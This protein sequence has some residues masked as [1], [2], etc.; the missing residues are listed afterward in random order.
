MN[1]PVSTLVSI[2]LWMTL[3][4]PPLIPM[5]DRNLTTALLWS[6]VAS[7]TGI[8]AIAGRRIHT[9]QLVKLP[10]IAL[11][12]LIGWMLLTCLWSI[13]PQLNIWGVS[14]RY[15]GLALFSCVLILGTLLVCSKQLLDES[16]GLV[17]SLAY[18]SIAISI[19]ALLEYVGISLNSV[20][21]HSDPFVG[22]TFTVF[23]RPATTAQWLLLTLPFTWLYFTTPKLQWS[24]LAL[25]FLA[26]LST[27]SRAGL[28]GYICIL[29]LFLAQKTRLN[30]K[31]VLLALAG[32]ITVGT[33]VLVGTRF[34][35]ESGSRSLISRGHIWQ[36]A[37]EAIANQPFGYGIATERYA[38]QE[39]VSPNILLVEP[40]FSYVDKAHSIALDVSTTLGIVGLLLLLTTVGSLLYTLQ[41][42]NS[43][44]KPILTA[45]IL[46]FSVSML[47]DFASVPTLVLFWLVCAL[48]WR[49]TAQ[50][51][52]TQ[53]QTVLLVAVALGTLCTI[54]TTIGYVHWAQ[55]NIWNKRTTNNDIYYG[56]R[57]ATYK[58][59]QI[60]QTW[61]R[62]PQ[63]YYSS[64]EYAINNSAMYSP[65]YI[66]AQL[67]AGMQLTN[68]KDAILFGLQGLWQAKQNRISQSKQSFSTAKQLSSTSVTV[69]LLEEH[70]A[71]LVQDTPWQQAVSNQ[72]QQLLPVQ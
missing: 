35:T 45:S 22:R 66:E 6:G 3:V 65:E 36:A 1:V 61:T 64:I 38:L 18:S 69:L 44:F 63:L 4:L 47:F 40:I 25:G 5:V 39:Y 56:G 12:G 42:T 7:L 70:S 52:R 15:V 43:V 46:G 16:H 32:T 53:Q 24:V 55:A 59:E 13:A 51:K 23:D 60:L 2:G 9:R 50:A 34:T 49:T 10:T 58:H 11:C 29:A 71:D 48:L 57:Y 62:D 26:V 72:L 28:L 19:V 67:A 68:N 14:P 20:L 8:A 17:R 41:Q 30:G 21:W 33:L 54:A 37:V 27:G 31:H